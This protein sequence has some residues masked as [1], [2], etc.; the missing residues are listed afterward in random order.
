M[1]Q[2][3]CSGGTNDPHSF[4]ASKEWLELSRF[5]E[6]REDGIERRKALLEGGR[7]FGGGKG[8]VNSTA[9]DMV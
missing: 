2:H 7:S 1:S 3:G 4:L 5:V 8:I 9:M 6:S